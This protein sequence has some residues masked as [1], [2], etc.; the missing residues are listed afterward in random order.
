MNSLKNFNLDDLFGYHAIPDDKYAP[1]QNRY[2]EIINRQCKALAFCLIDGIP[3]EDEELPLFDYKEYIKLS[4]VT[5]HKVLRE[6]RA[7]EFEWI[8]NIIKQ[9]IDIVRQGFLS[10]DLDVDTL[11]QC[12]LEIKMWLN[13]LVTLHYVALRSANQYIGRVGIVDYSD[14]G[15]I[16]KNNDHTKLQSNRTP[17]PKYTNVLGWGED[18]TC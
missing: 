16:Y 12:I 8:P 13:Q 15:D 10:E 1:A 9:L 4:L 3:E 11:L 2:Y 17:S 5:F 6:C 14:C 18:A 7:T